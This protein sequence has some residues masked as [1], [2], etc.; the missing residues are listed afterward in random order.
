MFI[1][2]S[3]LVLILDGPVAGCRLR[4]GT[5]MQITARLGRVGKFLREVR[6]ELKKV[7]WPDRKELVS[8]TVVVITVVVIVGA[9]IGLIDFVFSQ[10]LKVFVR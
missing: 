4:K 3:A 10:G 6:A 8:S 1:R 2:G 5:N 7:A 9:F